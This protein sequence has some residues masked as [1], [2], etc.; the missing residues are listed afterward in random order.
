[1]SKKVQARHWSQV[2]DWQWP[3]FSP[4]EVASKGDGSLLIDVDAMTRLQRLRTRL[5]K[6]MIVTSAYRDPEHN[7]RVGG[8][9]SSYHMKGM[10]FDI[11]VDNHDPEEFEAAARAEGFSGFGYY[12]DQG[13]MHIDTGPSRSWGRPFP[14]RNTRFAPE[15]EPKR[16]KKAAKEGA[17]V[18]AVA[19]A[20]ERVVTEAAPMLPDAWVTAAFTVLA[21]VGLALVAR[22]A[23]RAGQE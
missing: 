6:P 13:F 10:A 3:N 23:V 22:R 17:G 21:I 11:R 14:K 5:G 18:A 9:K 15:P 2:K 4:A 19:V 8:A 12:P 20:A 1:M 16:A 7:R